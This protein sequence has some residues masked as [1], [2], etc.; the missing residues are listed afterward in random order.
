MLVAVVTVALGLA[1]HGAAL[2]VSLRLD[3]GGIPAVVAAQAAPRKRGT[4][5]ARV[6]RIAANL[7]GQ[8]GLAVVGFL[9]LEARFPVAWPG[10]GTVLAQLLV[11]L[12]FDDFCFYWQHRLLHR[13]PWLYRHV[14]RIHHRAY[15]P[16]P[17]EYLYV[18]PVEQM[19]GAIGIV[20]GFAVCL[21]VFGSASAWAVWIYMTFRVLQEFRLHSGMDL[22]RD[23]I[24]VSMEQHDLHHARPSVGGY[25]SL[26][27]LWDH[28]FG[29]VP[30]SAP[31]GGE[32]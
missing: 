28:V 19:L 3:R 23:P 25:G 30:P 17:L 27:R 9:A 4:L 14:H 21:L 7:G 1:L 10:A 24:F 26:T 15:A 32:G 29:T 18:H 22:L 13:V 31:G 6:P 20:L 5:L 16:V 8:W 2:V 11:I 12:L